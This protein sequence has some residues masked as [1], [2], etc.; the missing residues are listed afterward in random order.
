MLHMTLV[1]LFSNEKRKKT[2]YYHKVITNSYCDVCYATVVKMIFDERQM[3]IY[4]S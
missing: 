2:R 1:Q 4:W 3:N